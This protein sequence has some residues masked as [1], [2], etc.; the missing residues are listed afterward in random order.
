MVGAQA[1]LLPSLNS[2][3]RG[4]DYHLRVTLLQ[5]MPLQQIQYGQLI[6]IDFRLF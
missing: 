3:N 5:S 4:G 2:E 6:G 1:H